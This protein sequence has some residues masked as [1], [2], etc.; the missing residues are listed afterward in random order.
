MT[1]PDACHNCLQAELAQLGPGAKQPAPTITIQAAAGGAGLQ[2]GS[3]ASHPS[4]EEA[5]TCGQR[6]LQATCERL[7]QEVRQ[8]RAAAEQERGAAH[9][10]QAMADQETKDRKALQQQLALL[11]QQQEGLLAAAQDAQAAAA[12][13]AQGLRQDLGDAKRQAE[14]AAAEREVTCSTAVQEQAQG[15]A[16]CASLRAE[17]EAAHTWAKQQK[18]LHASL[19]AELEGARTT[20]AHNESR[21]A[22]ALEAAQAT[23]QQQQRLH[24]SAAAKAEEDLAQL[25]AQR[26]Q[27]AAELAQ[28][29]AQ[30]Q[31][32][33]NALA[34]AKAA[35]QAATEQAQQQTLHASA[36]A[37]AAAK[38]EADL[39]QLR[40][41]TAET[42]QAL[43]DQVAALQGEVGGQTASAGAAQNQIQALQGLVN[44]LE[45]ELSKQ[46]QSVDQLQKAVQQKGD[47]LKRQGSR[48]SDASAAAAKAQ[49]KN[50]ALQQQV[51][52]LEDEVDDAAEEAEIAEEEKLAL[53]QQVSQ[54]KDEAGSNAAQ[55][56]SAE[57]EKLALQQQVSQLKDEAG[58]NAAQAQS[59]KEEKLSLQQQVRELEGQ[60][61]S[62]RAATDEALKQTQQRHTDELQ[63]VSQRLREAQ[64]RSLATEQRLQVR[65]D[66][67]RSKVTSK[68]VSGE[69]VGVC[70]VEPVCQHKTSSSAWNC[71]WWL[72]CRAAFPQVGR[73]MFALA[74][75]LS[76]PR[77]HGSP[78][79]VCAPADRLAAALLI[80]KC[81]SLLDCVP[82]T[83]SD[84]SLRACREDCKVCV[85]AAGTHHRP[86]QE[87]VT[88]CLGH[89]STSARKA[90]KENTDSC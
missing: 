43:R 14:F 55:A 35:A 57:E 81:C 79:P 77:A 67:L 53:Q 9:K 78:C 16:M 7:Q 71:M 41:E 65:V 88:A 1:S 27:A 8:A 26:Q 32:A 44:Q 84:H 22:A 85:A 75:V 50:Q 49:E 66:R 51:S 33:L 69:P 68:K 46:V 3:A 59:A 72:F 29:Q 61:G 48:L 28:L 86:R 10:A 31:Q 74:G 56:Q 18:A 37:Q 13:E 90:G 15:Q 82:P 64:A 58:S 4:L 20:A 62:L 40:S 36:A 54:L 30:R 39:A 42:E 11:Q 6:D 80:Y 25:R 17:L 12:S 45:G 60:L 24:E 21:W 38:A 47:Q 89:P 63:E 76:G 70:G 73:M 34:A 52:Q 19:T 5:A 87:A 2:S 83:T 23:A